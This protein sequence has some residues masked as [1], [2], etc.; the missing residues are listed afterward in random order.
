MVSVLSLPN[1]LNFVFF[2]VLLFGN[3]VIRRGRSKAQSRLDNAVL[4]VTLALAASTVANL[5]NPLTAIL[6]WAALITPFLLIRLA[7]SQGSA[8]HSLSLDRL[9]IIF[10]FVQG[11]VIGFERFVLGK[12][13][14]AA[15]GFLT[16]QGAGHHVVGF[17]GMGTALY[18]AMRLIEEPETRG[19]LA[20]YVAVFV[21]VAMAYITGT[22]QSFLAGAVVAVSF[23]IT[24]RLR[25]PM[26]PAIAVTIGLALA[27]L[28]LWPS[29]T[30]SG[31]NWYGPEY[32]ANKGQTVNAIADQYG[33]QPY[34]VFFGLGPGESATKVAWTGAG[35]GNL[36]ASLRIEPGGVATDLLGVELS[37][38]SYRSSSLT[39]TWAT[40]LGVWGDLGLLGLLAYGWAW[41]A[42]A[43]LTLGR[44]PRLRAGLHVV[45][46]L[47]L[48]GFFYSWL[49]EP[50][51]T[52]FLGLP[53]AASIVRARRL[54]EP[55]A[56]ASTAALESS[57]AR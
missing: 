46:F 45:A 31:M 57:P 19:Q 17:I 12:T 22:M 41:W 11:A 18:L 36:I 14:D 2:P 20:M 44:L 6:L 39:S 34:Q 50:V 10:L 7:V 32:F 52:I 9:I 56:A 43:R 38:P 55:P 40:W 27:T 26:W 28:A 8:A 30:P 3:L 4:V 53:V 15:Q 42:M 33:Q 48:L 23:L 51:L 13:G 49:E 37:K 21:G 5:A 35:G 1:I 25:R 24:R 29:F 54:S 47:V 16:G